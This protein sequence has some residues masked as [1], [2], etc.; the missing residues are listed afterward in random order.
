MRATKCQATVGVTQRAAWNTISETQRRLTGRC[1]RS[2][3]PGATSAKGVEDPQ[4]FD[5]GKPTNSGA[6]MFQAKL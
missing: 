3:N 6:A 2:L 1:R 4:Q 5:L